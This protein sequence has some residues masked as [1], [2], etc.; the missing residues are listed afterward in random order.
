MGKVEV[1]IRPRICIYL[2][3][4]ILETYISCFIR[5]FNL[6]KF[7]YIVTIAVPSSI[8]SCVDSFRLVEI[9]KIY[10]LQLQNS[11]NHHVAF[12]NVN[13]QP[14]VYTT[15]DVKFADLTMWFGSAECEQ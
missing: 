14:A 4:C 3:A 7:K 10:T 13:L 15:Q 1:S 9:G 2:F 6:I 12:Q 8:F 5:P 11:Y